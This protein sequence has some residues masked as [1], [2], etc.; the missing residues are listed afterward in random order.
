LALLTEKKKELE[1]L[2]KAL[3]EKEV[4][5]QS[6]VEGLIGK[7]PFGEKKPVHVVDDIPEEHHAKSAE[8]VGTDGQVGAQQNGTPSNQTAASEPGSTGTESAIND[9]LNQTPHY[10]K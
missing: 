6:D 2:A 8:E 5:F 10:S 7:R 1:I 4:L 3:L 9:L